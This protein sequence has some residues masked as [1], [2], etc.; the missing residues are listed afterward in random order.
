MTVQHLQAVRA[1]LDA[2]GPQPALRAF[3]DFI[4]WPEDDD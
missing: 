4:I 3:D 1:A 2:I